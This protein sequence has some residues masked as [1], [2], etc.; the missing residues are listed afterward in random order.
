MKRN[1]GAFEVD[2][3]APNKTC[4]YEVIYSKMALF[5]ACVQGWIEIDGPILSALPAA[6]AQG[7]PD[8]FSITRKR[9]I[10]RSCKEHQDITFCGFRKN[11]L[12]LFNQAS[13]SLL[14]YLITI[15]TLST[16][17]TTISF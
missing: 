17:I 1:K 8:N 13:L 15:H 10:L 2:K 6:A 16:A 7:K 3:T 5:T 14:M 12:K 9:L 11:K 4:V